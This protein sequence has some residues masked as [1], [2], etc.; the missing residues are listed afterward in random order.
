MPRKVQIS[1]YE[2][3]GI[4]RMTDYV[5]GELLVEIYADDVDQEQSLV[6]FAE[7][8]GYVIVEEY[9]YERQQ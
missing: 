8:L 7:K 3:Q 6:E 9:E 4:S 5:S 1:V 2:E